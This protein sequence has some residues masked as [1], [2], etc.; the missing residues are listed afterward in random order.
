MRLAIYRG[1][2]QEKGLSLLPSMAEET[3][4]YLNPLYKFA[5]PQRHIFQR[6]NSRLQYSKHPESGH[7][8]THTLG[9][10]SYGSLERIPPKGLDLLVITFF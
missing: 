7:G 5:H 2:C 9:H 10:H 6:R 3:W 4:D 8:H 1:N